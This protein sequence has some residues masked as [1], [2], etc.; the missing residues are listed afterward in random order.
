MKK[1]VVLVCLA[2]TLLMTVG[3]GT[4]LVTAPP[5][6]DI[7]LLAELEPASARV[8]MKNWYVL[9]GL[10]PITNNNTNDLIAKHG[11]KQVRVK[12]YWSF[13]DALINAVLGIVSIWTN[14][15]EIEGNLSK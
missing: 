4:V 6:S 11:L 3:C 8:T 9:W 14:T 10:V 12:T 15:V 1:T 2:A 13:V 7:R 5:K